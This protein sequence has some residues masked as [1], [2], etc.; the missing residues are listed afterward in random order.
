MDSISS[1]LDASSDP[2]TAI[3]RQ[4]QQE[5]ALNNAR[6]LID[7]SGSRNSNNI[8]QRSLILIT[9][10]EQPLLSEMRTHAWQFVIEE[11]GDMPY[12]M[13]GEIH[14]DVEYC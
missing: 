6:Q 14:G 4:I 5:A 7:V 10:N 2:K 12:T 13:Y 9:E 11:R 3:V 8:P 1:S